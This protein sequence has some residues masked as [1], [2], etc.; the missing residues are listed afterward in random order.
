[1]TY[2]FEVKGFAFDIQTLELSL[3]SVPE[4]SNFLSCKLVLLK[5][6]IPEALGTSNMQV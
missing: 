5:V 4:N 6:L 2:M 1:M 3:Y